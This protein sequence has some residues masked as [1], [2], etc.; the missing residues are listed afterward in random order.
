MQKHPYRCSKQI[1]KEYLIAINTII[2]IATTYK[3]S[4]FAAL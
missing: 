2:L 1:R 4:I 3:F